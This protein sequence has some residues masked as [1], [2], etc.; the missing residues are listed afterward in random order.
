MPLLQVA[1]R[2]RN[3]STFYS[4]LI[5]GGEREAIRKL[6]VRLPAAGDATSALLAAVAPP[7]LSRVVVRVGNTRL[8]QDDEVVGC[9]ATVKEK[10]DRTTTES[11]GSSSADEPPFKNPQLKVAAVPNA[12]RRCVRKMGP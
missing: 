8:L 2:V 5:S 6:A 3:G 9:I 7:K 10:L 1:V 4:R 12:V 11:F